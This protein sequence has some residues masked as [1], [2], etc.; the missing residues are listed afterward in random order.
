MMT[1]GAGEQEQRQEQRQ[2]QTQKQKPEQKQ[3]QKQK[4][5]QTALTGTENELK[6]CFLA[7]EETTDS[8]N[9]VE[10]AS[11]KPASFA[12]TTTGTLFLVV[13]DELL[14]VTEPLRARG[15]GKEFSKLADF[16][17]TLQFKLPQQNG[18]PTQLIDAGRIAEKVPFCD[19]P[20]D[21]D[22]A[23]VVKATQNL[24]LVDGTACLNGYPVWERLENERNDFYAAFKVYRDMRYGL[25]N[26][27]AKGSSGDFIVQNRSMAYVA[28]K[29][30]IPGYTLSKLSKVFHWSARV[31]YYDDY[32]E[33]ARQKRRA[34]QVQLMQNDHLAIASELV[35]DAHAYLVNNIGKMKPKEVLQM[36]EMGLKYSRLSVGLASDKVTSGD[37][38]TL[39]IYNNKETNNNTLNV[40]NTNNAFSS[41]IE[42][43]LHADLKSEDNLLDI[44]HVLQRSGAMNTAVNQN[45]LETGKED[46][47]IGACPDFVVEDAD[48]TDVHTIPP[49]GPVK[50]GDSYE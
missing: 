6:D 33:S 17:T 25:M 42:R 24:E 34:M 37:T 1:N 47:A 3:E 12:N 48:Y 18:K 2:E 50:A 23:L 14:K 39:A 21:I 4:Q 28:K 43:Q 27:G 30:G 44:L 11:A 15:L 5:K 22:D 35:A 41:D 20:E 19:V 40:N 9:A 38:P 31:A 46:S 7:S 16:V 13:D 26:N 49:A 36:L 29:L 10:E 45:I 8:M 32:M